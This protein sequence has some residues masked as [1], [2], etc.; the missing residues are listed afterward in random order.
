MTEED[1]RHPLDGLG[2]PVA[3]DHT[4]FLACTA[5]TD[6]PLEAEPLD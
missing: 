2:N 5:L 1:L 6:S 3:I 4:S